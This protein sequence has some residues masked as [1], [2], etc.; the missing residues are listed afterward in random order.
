MNRLLEILR[1]ELARWRL[2]RAIRPIERQIAEARRNHKPVRH[3][4]QAKRS[5]ILFGLRGPR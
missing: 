5:L 1:Y 3:L 2:R 4:I